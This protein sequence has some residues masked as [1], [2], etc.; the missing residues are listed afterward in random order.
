MKIVKNKNKL[1]I[2]TKPCDSVEEGEEIAAKLIQALTEFGGI[3]LSAN[4]IGI[5]KSVCVVWARQDE[6][7]PK[8]LINPTIVDVSEEKISYLEG[9]LSLPGKRIRTIRHKSVTVRCDNWINELTFDAD[10]T[11]FTEKNFWNDKGLLESVC[12]QHEIDHL[13]GKLITDKENRVI[14]KP[15]KQIKYSRNEKVMIQKDEETQFVKYKKA[16]QLLEE[17]WVI[18]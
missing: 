15:Q 17:G 14:V 9:C 1:S 11:E 8:I 12:I 7:E 2:P 4:Q 10:E 5:N 13:N 16:L 18:I 3:G 6:E